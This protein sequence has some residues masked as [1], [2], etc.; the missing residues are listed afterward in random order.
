MPQS[1]D[2]KKLDNKKVP[3]VYERIS[4]RWGNEIV[5]RGGWREGTE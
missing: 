1:T 5:I 2:P 3:R 4:F